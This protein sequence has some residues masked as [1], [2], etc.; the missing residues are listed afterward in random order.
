VSAVLVFVVLSAALSPGLRSRVVRSWRHRI[1]AARIRRSVEA[2]PDVCQ[3]VAR[4]LVVGETLLR[5]LEGAASGTYL[6]ADVDRLAIEYRRGVVLTRAAHRWADRS[7]RSEI[8][9]LAAAIEMASSSV[10]ARPELF[11]HVALTLRR[12]GELRL[13]ARTQ[14]SQAYLSTWVVAALPWLLSIGIAVEGGEPA[15]VLLREPIGWVCLLGA[16]A[17]DAL[18]I[19]WMFRLISAATT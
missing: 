4:R 13:E 17:L 19:A 2:L 18:A 15:Q 7:R 10:G 12:R 14:A 3:A 5:A 8:A 16:V 9:M 11:D 1:E 6:A